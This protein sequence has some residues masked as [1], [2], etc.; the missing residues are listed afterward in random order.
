VE[1][2]DALPW[3]AISAATGG[4][5]LTFA[6]VLAVMRG[7]LIPRKQHDDVIH[8]RNEWRAE[9]RIKDA[10]IAEKDL[11]LRYMSEVGETQK[12]V[13]VTLQ[14]LAEGERR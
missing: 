1:S 5:L 3:P 10:Q 14:Q 8:D 4:W 11:Q 9:S 13:L 2:L 6:F 7:G 12:N